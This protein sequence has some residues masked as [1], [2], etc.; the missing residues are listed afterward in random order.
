MLWENKNRINPEKIEIDKHKY[1]NGYV[2]ELTDLI[3]HR[4]ELVNRMGEEIDK[5]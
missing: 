3:N 5:S 4:I 1:I 2:S